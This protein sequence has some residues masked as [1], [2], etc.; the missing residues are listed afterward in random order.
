M[1]TA[2]YGIRPTDFLGA[3]GASRVE[4]TVL[5]PMASLQ[6]SGSVET[7]FPSLV[8]TWGREDAS[9]PRIYGG[10]AR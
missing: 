6:S 7:T 8:E 4:S 10:A 3:G 1:L 5:T 2:T 9:Q